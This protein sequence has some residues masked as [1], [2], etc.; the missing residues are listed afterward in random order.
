VFEN[1]LTR[2]NV[3]ILIQFYFLGCRNV[4]AGQK[5]IK[6]HISSDASIELYELDL[7]SF[8][9]VKSFAQQV[10]TNHDQIHILVNNGKLKI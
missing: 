7:K 10:L 3:H 1:K 5:T 9:S 6:Q 4:E 2:I 8:T